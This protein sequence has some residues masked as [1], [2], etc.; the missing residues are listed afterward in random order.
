MMRVVLATPVT[1]RGGVWRHVSDLARG[2]RAQGCDVALA[3]PRGAVSLR[4]EATASGLP[5]QGPVPSSRADIWHLHLADTYDR[6]VLPELVLASRTAGGV[7]VTEHL[8]RSN[9]SDPTESSGGGSPS[10]GAWPAKTIFKRTEFAFCDRIVCVSEASRRFLMTRYGVSRRKVTTIPNGIDPSSGPSPW[11]RGTARFVAIGSVIAQKGF[12]VLIEAVALAHSPWRVDVIGDG[13]HLAGLR[14]RADGRQ[15]PVHFAGATTDV[16]SALASATAL[17][18]PS[19]WEAWPYVAMEAMAQGRPV[20]ASR[21]DGL[22]EIVDDGTTGLL[23][24]PGDP[25]ALAGALDRL[26]GDSA[27]AEMLGAAGHERVKSFGLGGMVDAVLG[28]Y[29]ATLGTGRGRS[30]SGTRG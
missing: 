30:P 27:L 20:V 3:L 26:A 8:P 18:V 14:A 7:I 6:R 25:Y 17:V 1:S 24:D 10:L 11:P 19:L 16:T 23:V 13:P 9:A 28:V 15:L 5:V 12:D 4:E 22:P 2:L 29:E 21:V